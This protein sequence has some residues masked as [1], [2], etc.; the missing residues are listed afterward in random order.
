MKKIEMLLSREQSGASMVEYA[1][2]VAAISALIA[3]TV[4]LLGM[5]IWSRLFFFNGDFVNQGRISE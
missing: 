2:M 4:F 5:N 1:I 3:A